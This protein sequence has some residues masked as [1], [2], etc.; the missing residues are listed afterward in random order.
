MKRINPL[1][2]ANNPAPIPA[3]RAPIGCTTFWIKTKKN[4]ML[5]GINNL[6]MG[7]ERPK[8]DPAAELR[9]LARQFQMCT[10]AVARIDNNEPGTWRCLGRI[11]PIWKEDDIDDIFFAFPGLSGKFGKGL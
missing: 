9:S 8:M 3:C 11:L 1:L 2:T 5:F 10:I 4:E 7:V 6:R